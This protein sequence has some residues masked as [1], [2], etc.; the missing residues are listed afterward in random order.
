MS[1]TTKKIDDG[2]PA[3]PILSEGQAD[4]RGGGCNTGYSFRS[5]GGMSKR[6]EFAR[7]AM[8]AIL[9]AWMTPEAERQ[10]GGGADFKEVARLS[11]EMADAMLAELSAK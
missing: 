1:E 7:S 8:Q 10:F 9:G 3:F 4:G 5:S 11:R 2:G 6:E